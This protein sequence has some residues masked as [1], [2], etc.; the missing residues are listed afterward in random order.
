[1]ELLAGRLWMMMPI[2]IVVIVNLYSLKVHLL[3]TAAVAAR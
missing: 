1:M 2:A 3:K